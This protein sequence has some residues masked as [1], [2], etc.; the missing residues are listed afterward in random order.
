MRKEKK[1]QEQCTYMQSDQEELEKLLESKRIGTKKEVMWKLDKLNK[2]IESMNTH[3]DNIVPKVLGNEKKDLI[4]WYD[5]TK[6]CRNRLK[7]QELVKQTKQTRT[8]INLAINRRYK[9][10][11][12]EI[13]RMLRSVLNKPTN[14]IQI[15]KV[16]K[17]VESK[18]K[19]VN[20]SSQ[21]LAK[22]K[23]HFK[24][25]FREKKVNWDKNIQKE[26]YELLINSNTAAGLS[27][28]GFNLIKEGKQWHNSKKRMLQKIWK[29]NLAN[30]VLLKVK[31]L[32]ITIRFSNDPWHITG[33]EEEQLVNKNICE[34]FVKRQE[35]TGSSISEQYDV[36]KA[37][38]LNRANV[39]QICTERVVEVVP[40]EKKKGILAN[41]KKFGKVK[42][43]IGREKR[44]RKK[45]D[46]TERVVTT[47]SVAQLQE[48]KN[49]AIKLYEN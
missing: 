5:Q 12:S 39:I 33:A 24:K 29:D 18:W 17:Q 40:K 26:F 44:V 1:V 16:F 3:C 28:I 41:D 23:M 8:K 32:E 42:E 4:T 13:E 48:R 9:M 43:K 21:V 7:V 38:R 31:E 14:K 19:L 34:M 37:R 11:K 36:K 47:R 49:S 27:E 25:Q 20:S 15:D 30:Q 6:L 35:K 22:T 46:L 45:V 2:E 10:I